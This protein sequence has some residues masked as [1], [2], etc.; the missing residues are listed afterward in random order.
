M[1]AARGRARSICPMTGSMLTT[2][3]GSMVWT[4]ANTTVPRLNSRS[5]GW[6]M[7]MARRVS[8]TTP[9]RP[10][11]TSQTKFFT[12]ALVQNGNSTSNDSSRWRRGF[13]D[14]SQ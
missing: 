8:A 4:M 5:G 6:A 10:S 14:D 2:P 13:C 1:A 12:S 11:S 9:L 7:P 3:S